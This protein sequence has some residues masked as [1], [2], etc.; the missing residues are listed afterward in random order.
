[1]EMIVGG[2]KEVAVVGDPALETTQ[3]LLHVVF[4]PYRPNT[5][6]ALAKANVEGEHPIPLLS[7]RTMR[8]NVPTVYVCQNFMCKMPVTMVAE[9]QELL[10]Q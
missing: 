7:Y 3:Q 10:L 6:A 4:K 5:I 9:V 1:M 2:V 8:G